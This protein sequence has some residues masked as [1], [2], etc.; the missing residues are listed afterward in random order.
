MR[1][2]LNTEE[3]ITCL[4]TEPDSGDYHLEG[5]CEDC[6]VFRLSRCNL[7]QAQDRYRTGRI[8]Q[9]MYE[10]YCHVWAHLSPHGALP[11]FR[12]DPAFPRVRR[13]ARKLLAVRGFPV[14]GRWRN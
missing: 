13:I 9:D 3:E 5:C 14:P 6:D 10:A 1:D 2:I 11:G 7:M 4:L 12:D 8:G